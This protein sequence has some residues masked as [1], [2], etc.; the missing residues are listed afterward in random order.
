MKLV[1]PPEVQIGAHTFRIRWSD[2]LLDM[3]KIKASESAREQIIRLHTGL[4][5]SDTFECL[6]H[7]LTHAVEYIC[8]TDMENERESNTI[9]RSAGITQFLMSMGIEPDFS[10][11]PEEIP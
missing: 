9:S 8:G 4:A 7:E 1:I 10:K 6:I 5:D 3:A 11:V 2:K